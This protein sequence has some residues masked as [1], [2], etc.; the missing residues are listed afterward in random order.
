[1]TLR[2]DHRCIIYSDVFIR[3]NIKEN[4]PAPPDMVQREVVTFCYSTYCRFRLGMHR[5]TD[6]LALC[7]DAFCPYLLYFPYILSWFLS[8]FVRLPRSTQL[9]LPLILSCFSPL[10]LLVCLSQVDPRAPLVC[11]ADILP[12]SLQIIEKCIFRIAFLLRKQY[13][14][15]AERLVW[16]F[17][18]RMYNHLLRRFF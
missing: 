6:R 15:Y 5:L 8:E 17:R 18:F 11:S 4:H 7:R 2:R 9:G 10:S 3:T 16:F 1:M 14:F 13:W 12:S